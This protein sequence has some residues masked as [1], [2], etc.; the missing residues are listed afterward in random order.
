MIPMLAAI[1]STYA[2]ARLIQVP[3][4]HMSIKSR[5]LILW[6]V[7]VP[8]IFLIGWLAKAIVIAGVDASDVP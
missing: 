4:E 8:A 1:V 3:V 7:S 5:S 2:I 6:I